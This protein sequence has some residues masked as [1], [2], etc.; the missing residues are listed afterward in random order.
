MEKTL[1]IVRHGQT[2]LNKQGIVQG[3]GRDTDL[4]DEGRRQANQFFE[5]YKNVPFDKIYISELKR[6]QQSIQQFIDLG[7]PF[8]KLE[9]L[10]ELA[11]GVHEGQPATPETKAAFLDLMRNWLDG[12]LDV[13]FDGGESPNEVK[14]R[15]LEA[16]DIIMSHPEEK[17]VLVCMHGRALR[18]LMCILTEQPLTKMDTFPH[19]NLVL[20]KVAYN[21]SKFEIVEANNAKHLIND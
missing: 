2:D 14:T 17:T 8:E 1:Y 12:N 20:Y 16:L 15:Q 19:Q 9:G 6:T 7:I 13:K 10:D 21:G 3:R 5:A 4:N 18:L 11:W